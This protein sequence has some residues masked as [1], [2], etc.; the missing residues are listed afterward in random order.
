MQEMKDNGT[1]VPLARKCPATAGH[2]LKDIGS[3]LLLNVS[4][5]LGT[6]TKREQKF[7]KNSQR[8]SLLKVSLY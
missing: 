4:S 1:K 7:A 6:H 3:L 2:W 8:H 5:I